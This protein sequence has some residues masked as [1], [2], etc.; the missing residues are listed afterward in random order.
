MIVIISLII[1]LVVAYAKRR[2]FGMPIRSQ[3]EEK[4]DEMIFYVYPSLYLS[5]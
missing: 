3:V 1:S 4:R 2:T 5:T